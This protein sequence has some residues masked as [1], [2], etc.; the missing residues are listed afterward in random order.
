MIWPVPRCKLCEVK[1]SRC[2]AVAVA[3]LSIKH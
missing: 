1:V 3:V 2:A